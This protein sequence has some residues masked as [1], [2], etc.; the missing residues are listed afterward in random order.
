MST[1]APLEL[2]IE[3][4][5]DALRYLDELHFWYSLDD[6]RRCQSCGRSFTGRQ[7]RVIELQGTRGK[8]QLECPTAGCRSSPKDWAGIARLV[9]RST[10]KA[11][12]QQRTHHDGHAC[13]VLR[14]KRVRA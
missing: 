4:K 7:V 1:Y 10:E 14:V 2:C 5:L 8:L 3:D 11:S 12:S 9:G 13:T 6:K